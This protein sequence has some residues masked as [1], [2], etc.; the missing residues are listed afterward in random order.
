V[1][2][3]NPNAQKGM[4]DVH[5]AQNQRAQGQQGDSSLAHPSGITAKGVAGEVLKGD[6]MNIPANMMELFHQFM[7]SIA[8]KDKGK[9]VATQIADVTRI[10]KQN[11]VKEELPKEVAESSAQGEARGN[12][13][14]YTPYCYRCLTRGQAKEECQVQLFC[15]ICESVS[16]AKGRCPLLKKAKTMFAMTCGYAV[17]GLGFYYIPHSPATRP[18]SQARAAIIWVVEGEM[19]SMQVQAE[20][21][22]LVPAQTAWRVEELGKN[23][24]NTIFPSKGEMNRMR[25]WGIVQTKDRKAKLQIEE[26]SGRNIS[27]QTMRK[28]SVQV[29]KLPSELRDFL[30]IWAID[31]ILGVTK[32]VDMVFTR[33]FSRARLQVLVLD[34]ALIPISCD[35]VIGDD[36]YELQF[37][38]EPVE[39]IDSP[40]LLKMDEDLDDMGD[41]EG[42]GEE[43]GQDFMLEDSNQLGGGSGSLGGQMERHQDVQSIELLHFRGQ[44]IFQKRWKK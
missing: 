26:A 9:D 31:S 20:M 2:R 24:F 7:D 38:V 13:V 17:D 15:D 4:A 19:N 11:Q 34:P 33:K 18:R 30:T 3:S 6:G 42:E 25:E 21:Q 36:I 32:E 44:M 41:R 23:R 14:I 5:G 35:V 8:N 12:N 1:P 22:R 39:M 28:V 27:K 37:K 16:H 40:S 10:E 29:T 43:K